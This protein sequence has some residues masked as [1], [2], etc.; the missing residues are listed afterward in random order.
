MA[1]CTASLPRA[2]GSTPG[3]DQS[4]FMASGHTVRRA[5]LRESI[6]AVVCPDGPSGRD[7]SGAGGGCK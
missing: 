5:R 1:E 7:S 2:R 3:A 6:T 4:S